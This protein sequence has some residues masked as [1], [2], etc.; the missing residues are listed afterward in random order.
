MAPWG[1]VDN[2]IMYDNGSRVGS[3][4]MRSYARANYYVIR[5]PNLANHDNNCWPHDSDAI[6]F[7]T[8]LEPI[9]TGG[10]QENY[11]ELIA[12]AKI[13]QPDASV[14]EG[15]EVV[16]ATPMLRHHLRQNMQDI[17]ARAARK[18]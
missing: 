2:F 5:Q 1:T 18:V 13:G 15:D 10:Q 3:Y 17:A 11:Q 7:T 14:G 9:K 8:L 16:S 6:A 12:F 4:I